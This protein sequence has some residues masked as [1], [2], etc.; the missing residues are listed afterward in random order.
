[1][2]SLKS[3]FFFLLSLLPL[4]LP[5]PALLPPFFEPGPIRTLIIDAGHGGKDP[6]AS[7]RLYKEKDITLAVALK[8]R[9]LVQ[10]RMPGLR[11]VLTREDDRFIELKRRGE[12]AQAARGDFFVSIHCNA[13]RQRDR[14]GAETYVLGTNQGQEN[15]ATIIQENQAILFEDNYREVYEGFDPSSPE[16]LIFFRLLKNAYRNE[17]ARLAGSIQQAYQSRLRRVDR[18]VKQA[19]FVVLYMAGMPAVL[20]EIGFL[21]NPQEEIFLGSEAGQIYIAEAI[22]QALADY[23]R[24][25]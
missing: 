15:Y 16:G 20:T 22:Y 6:G 4:A 18:G 5:A 3:G 14:M 11:V 25:R 17:S 1:M 24:D 8:L 19:P 12:L 9:G 2:S 21:S 10:E 23:N 13:M 7:G